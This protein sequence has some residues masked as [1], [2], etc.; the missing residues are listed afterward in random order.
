MLSWLFTIRK[1]SIYEKDVSDWEAILGLAVRWD[2]PEVKNL[3]VR[4]LEK[5]IDI[6]DSKR[7]KLYHANNVDRNVLIPYYARLCEREA[8]L[9]REEGEDIGMET[10]INVSAGREEARAGRLASGVRSPVTP[11]VRGDEL[12]EVVREVFKIAPKTQDK[13]QEKE[14]EKESTTGGL[15]I[16]I[17]ENSWY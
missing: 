14:K 8:R 2:F 7:I 3:A 11:T 15:V 4:E 16:I 1:Y 17:Y 12:F 13:D 9:T 5:K 6:P 10:V